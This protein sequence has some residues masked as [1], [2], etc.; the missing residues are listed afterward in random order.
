MGWEFSSND[1][2]VALDNARQSDMVV[3]WFPRLHTVSLPVQS[4]LLGATHRRT[5]RIS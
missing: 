2:V 5:K 1:H 3:E 4:A